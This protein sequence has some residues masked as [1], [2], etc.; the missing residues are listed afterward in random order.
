MD[1]IY[2]IIVWNGDLVREKQVYAVFV[3]IAADI[4]RN[5]DIARGDQWDAENVA[6]QVS[7]VN[8]QI[9][10]GVTDV[11]TSTAVAGYLKPLNDIGVAGSPRSGTAPWRF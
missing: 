1:V 9:I 3:V 10:G 4:V 11:D 6:V 8:D 5:C 2:T 7:M